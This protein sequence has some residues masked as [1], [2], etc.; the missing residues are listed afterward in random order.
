[1]TMA[2]VLIADDEF[3]IRL[4]LQQILEDLLEEPVELLFAANG[5]EALQV[6]REQEPEIVFLD[7]MMPKMDGFEVCD[8]VKHQLQLTKPHIVM[9]TAKSQ[10][11]DQAKGQLAGADDYLTK[12]FDLDVITE[13]VRQ[14]LGK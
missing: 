11:G 1:M 2:K 4:L 14:I 3:Y 10:M 8:I 6:I 9:L 7:V 13:K 12:P 5:E